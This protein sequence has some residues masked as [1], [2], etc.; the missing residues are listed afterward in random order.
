MGQQTGLAPAVM[1]VLYC[2]VGMKKAE[3]VL[4]SSNPQLGRDQQNKVIDAGLLRSAACEGLHGPTQGLH[5]NAST[6]QALGVGL[7]A[8]FN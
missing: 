6:V 3:L 4:L 7:Q 2:T 8:N 5:Y 1:W